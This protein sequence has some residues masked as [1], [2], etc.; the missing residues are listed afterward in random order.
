MK[1][2]MEILLGTLNYLRNDWWILLIGSLIAV[3]I[4][5]YVDPNQFKSYIDKKKNV[6][7]IGS[8]GFGAFTPLCACG[9]M[10]VILAMFVSQMTWGPVMAFLVSS[11]LTGPSEYYFQASYFG[12][13]FANVVLIASI[14]M[15]LIAGYIAY[16]LDQKSTFFDQQFRIQPTSCSSGNCTIDREI[17]ISCCDSQVAKKKTNVLKQ[18]KL[19][20]LVKE[21]YELGIKKILVLFILFVAISQLVELLIPEEWI[22]QLFSNEKTYSVPLAATIGLP[23]YVSGPSA[24]PLLK[25][26]MENGAGEGAVLA[27]LI[28]G[29]ATGVPVMIGMSTLFKKRA[30]MFY[31]GFVYVSGILSGY[32]YD[33]ILNV[34]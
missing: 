1:I 9:T 15:G 13:Q 5:V 12:F 2:V 30:I 8:V 25:T 16:Y 33:L 31:V 19:K 17:K 21:L 6:S 24:I 34:F 27:F 11:P 26:L 28:T 14:L 7:I 32:L 18:L 23:L 22:F 3:V 20:S 10:A 4:K 29:K